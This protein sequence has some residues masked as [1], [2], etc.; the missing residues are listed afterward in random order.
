MLGAQ[1]VRELADTGGLARAVHPDHEHYERFGRAVDDE[2]PLAW[3]EDLYQSVTHRIEQGLDVVE[4]VERHP[5]VQIGE[6]VVGGLNA[7]I[8]HEQSRL[9]VLE[10]GGID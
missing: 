10:H 4:L 2:W 6:D 5:A 7:D 8:G 1:P 3:R 9:E